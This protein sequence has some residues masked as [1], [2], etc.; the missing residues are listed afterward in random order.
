MNRLCSIQILVYVHVHVEKD[1]LQELKP[2]SR[3]VKNNFSLAPKQLKSCIENNE[4]KTKIFLLVN[5]TN[6]YR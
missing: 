4:K 3:V 6:I 1:E 2:A 5:K